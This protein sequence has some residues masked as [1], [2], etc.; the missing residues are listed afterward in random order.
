MKNSV[1]CF[2]AFVAILIYLTLPNLAISQGQTL[3]YRP[4]EEACCDPIIAPCSFRVK[5][6]IS[7]SDYCQVEG[8]IP[9]SEPPS[10]GG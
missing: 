9:C 10:M 2:V 7:A 8:Q 4:M 5:C 3:G 6:R 1:K